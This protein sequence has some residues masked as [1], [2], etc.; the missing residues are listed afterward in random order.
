MLLMLSFIKPFTS[1]FPR[2]NIHDL[3]T[4]DLLHQMI[5]GT[6]KDHLVTWVEHYIRK[7]HSAAAANR[8][9]DDIDRR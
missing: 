9:M 5:K 6:F 7:T 8:I 3:I 4:P 2:A 1:Y